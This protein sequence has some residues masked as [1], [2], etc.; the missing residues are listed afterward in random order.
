MPPLMAGDRATVTD[1]ALVEGHGSRVKVTGT[2]GYADTGKVTRTLLRWQ[3]H[4]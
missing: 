3:G 4:H 1:C 2:Q